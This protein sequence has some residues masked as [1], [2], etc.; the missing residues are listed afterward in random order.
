MTPL[1]LLL[2]RA[3]PVWLTSSW[4]TVMSKWEY[5]KGWAVLSGKPCILGESFSRTTVAPGTNTFAKVSQLLVLIAAATF[6]SGSYY[7]HVSHE[8]TWPK[9][10]SKWET[11]SKVTAS[12]RPS[13]PLG[14]VT[15]SMPGA[16]SVGGH[17]SVRVPQRWNGLTVAAP[18]LLSVRHPGMQ[19]FALISLTTFLPNEWMRFVKATCLYLKGSSTTEDVTRK[20]PPQERN[21][22]P[23]IRLFPHIQHLFFSSTVLKDNLWFLIYLH[24]FYDPLIPLRDGSIFF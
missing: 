2:Q 11:S 17:L 21:I 13:D 15:C 1:W 6:A 10:P 14:W 5:G 19:R 22:H 16:V 4:F 7:P 3:S 12:V 8:E 23:F 24:T 18:S 9:T 20:V